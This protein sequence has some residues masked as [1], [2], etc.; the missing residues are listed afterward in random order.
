MCSLL[1]GGGEA[2][3]QCG[4]IGG[5]FVYL[6]EVDVDVPQVRECRASLVTV[7]ITSDQRLVG[8]DGLVVLAT[9]LGEHG[10]LHRGESGILRVGV[11][12]DEL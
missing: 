3:A 4:G 12:L 2:V 10:T 5:I 1:L 6:V 7:G 9:V 11:L 8:S